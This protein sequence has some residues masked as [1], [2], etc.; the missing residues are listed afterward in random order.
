MK[1]IERKFLVTRK[2]VVSG[3][4]SLRVCQGY[5]LSENEGDARVRIENNEK[6]FLTIKKRSSGISRWEFE[7]SVPLEDAEIMLNALCEGRIVEKERYLI[8]YKGRLWEVDVF[9]GENRGLIVA[10]VE[11]DS[12][13]QP[14]EKPL[15][16]GGEVTEDPRYLN[17]NLAVH[18]F[19]E[20]NS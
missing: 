13:D 1:E 8:P 15:W 20:W 19:R 3:H 5:I 6:A 11:L 2:D 9:A 10:E 16:A 7:Y 12:E 18:P 17:K 4:R 14:F